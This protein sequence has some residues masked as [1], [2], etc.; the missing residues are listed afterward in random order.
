MSL[1][2]SHI[3][4]TGGIASGK[5]TVA[6]LLERHGL[7]ILDADVMSRE[8]VEPGTPAFE[9]I[10][11]EFGSG[12]L[13]GEGRLDRRALA[14]IVF[15]EPGRRKA[16]EAIVHPAVRALARS[17]VS[18]LAR[19][20]VDRRPRAVVEVIPLLYEVGLAGEFDAVWVVACDP[21]QQLCRLQDRDGLDPEAARA[22]LAAQWPIERKVALADRVIPN[23]GT[24]AD[25]ERV[26][27]ALLG[28][29][30]LDSGHSGYNRGIGNPSAK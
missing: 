25:L 26:V 6:R 7:A 4:L 29:L 12:V 13:D 21:E 10:T 20:P 9:R 3:G 1:P 11:H 23:T 8:V 14:A 2:F 5:S 28:E 19:L 22:R 17:Q 30:G 15:A 18:A 16:L 24:L 27:D